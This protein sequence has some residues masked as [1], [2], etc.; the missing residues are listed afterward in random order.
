[1]SKQ[2]DLFKREDKQHLPTPQSHDDLNL[3]E[4]V[5]GMP[6]AR[7]ATASKTTSTPWKKGER[8][9]DI[10]MDNNSYRIEWTSL[11]STQGKETEERH[12]YRSI[13][14]NRGLPGPYAEDVIVALLKL[15]AEEHFE[16]DKIRIT[17]HQLLDLMRW[18]KT[19]YYYDRLRETL[20]Q[21]VGMSVHTN[22][23]FHPEKNRYVEKA[24]NI[25]SDMEIDDDGRLKDADCYVRWAKGTFELFQMGFTKP[26]DT[27][28]FY[29]LEDPMAKRLYR[30]LDKHLRRSTAVEIDVLE[31][32]HKVL[33]YGVNY[34]YPSQILRK[35]KPRLDI[36]KQKGFCRYDIIDDESHPSGS[37]F[38]FQRIS[39]YTSVIYPTRAN[40][41][42][43][44][45][46]RQVYSD[47]AEMLIRRYGWEPCLRQIEHLDYKIEQGEAPKSPGGWLK[48]AITHNDGEGYQ[49]PAELEQLMDEAREE[50]QRWCAEAFDAM[51]NQEKTNLKD[52]LLSAVSPKTRERIR[53]K[54]PGAIFQLVRLRNQKLLLTERP[55]E[56]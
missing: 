16:K 33:N 38:R 47:T 23:V 2:A 4:I 1:M 31:L 24:F 22:A 55:V 51:T 35:L 40:V 18:N 29:S 21:L 19:K 50:T 32:A 34:E 44:L 7:G 13:E 28:F 11:I 37:K 54:S 39:M 15:T 5:L 25:F 26:L 27:E 53:K 49:L 14:C 17:C 46:E 10:T 52:G 6:K 41:R 56:P 36:L 42:A 20:H 45:T 8:S 3:I 12:F 9:Y 48:R 43:A 30:W